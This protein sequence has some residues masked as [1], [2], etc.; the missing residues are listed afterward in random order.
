[1]EAKHLRRSLCSLKKDNWLPVIAEGLELL[2]EH[3]ATLQ[4]DLTSLLEQDRRRAAMAVDVVASEEAAK[5]LILLDVVRMPWDDEKLVSEQLQRFYEHFARGVYARVT[6]MRPATFGELRELI[7][8]F[9]PSLYLDGPNDVDW[10]FRNEIDAEREECLYVDYLST[11][12]GPRWVTPAGRESYW[13]AQ[14]DIL[15]LVTALGKAGC[16]S[17]E[18]LKIVRA[19]WQNQKL[20]DSTHWQVAEGINKNILN[21]L[22]ESSLLK[23]ELSQRDLRLIYHQWTFPLGTLDLDIVKVSRDELQAKRDQWLARQYM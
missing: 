7:N 1:M 12:E 18:G 3:V 16:L 8:T 19:A 17:H 10:V 14:D 6:P 9:R 23:S 15:D 22:Y 4:S 2:V 21:S 20:T 5:V 11:D 13:S